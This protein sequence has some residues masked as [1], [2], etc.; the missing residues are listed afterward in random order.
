V[1]FQPE[2]GLKANKDP[3]EQY[4]LAHYTFGS[5]RYGEEFPALYKKFIESSKDFLKKKGIDYIDINSK[6]EFINSSKKLF[7]DVVH[8]NKSGNEIIAKTINDYL[9]SY[10]P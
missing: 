10:Y 3:Q 6:T 4:S 1:V 7:I 9:Q 2:L 8:T 5:N